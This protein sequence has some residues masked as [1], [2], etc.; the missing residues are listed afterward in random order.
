MAVI[1]ASMGL[2][3]F[4]FPRG[5]GEHAVTFVGH[6]GHQAG[7]QLFFVINPKSGRAVI[8]A[9]NT[10]HGD[11]ESTLAK[12]RYNEGFQRFSQL[13]EAAITAIH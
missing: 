4:L 10:V 12:Q 7:F 9:S 13:M 5:S 11:G 2:S 1:A 3:F 6:T 8:A